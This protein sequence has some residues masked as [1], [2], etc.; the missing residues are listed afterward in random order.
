MAGNLGLGPVS[1]AAVAGGTATAVAPSSNLSGNLGFGAV[2]SGA[3]AVVGGLTV[4]ILGSLAGGNLGF[5]AV[6]STAVAGNVSSGT[7][8]VPP[9]IPAVIAAAS[10]QA[11]TNASFIAA[12][13]GGPVRAS[14]VVMEVL[15]PFAETAKLRP[16]VWINT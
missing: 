9:S 5:G 10:A 4:T 13:S 15:L 3:V 14:Q 6:A 1:S 8:L 7:V 11:L 12:G 16:F 2:A